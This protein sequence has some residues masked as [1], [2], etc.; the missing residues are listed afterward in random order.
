MAIPQSADCAPG[1]DNN[2]AIV[3]M[4]KEGALPIIVDICGD[5]YEMSLL[6]ALSLAGR[7][8]AVC[9][10]NEAVRSK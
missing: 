3:N 9:E 10:C 8:I 2:E 6:D 5:R 7:I 1:K 4:A